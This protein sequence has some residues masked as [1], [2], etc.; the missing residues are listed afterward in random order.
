M[1]R[2]GRLPPQ[3]VLVLPGAVTVHGVVPGPQLGVALTAGSS[4]LHRLSGA[5]ATSNPGWLSTGDTWAVVPCDG[6]ACARQDVSSIPGLYPQCQRYT[7]EF[8]AVTQ[9]S[10]IATRPP[11][12]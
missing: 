8:V 12:L 4:A 5:G 1:S 7:S 9:V 6:L 11:L 2:A 3:R 10:D